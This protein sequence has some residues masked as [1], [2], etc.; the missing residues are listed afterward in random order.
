MVQKEQP[1]L[2]TR[3]D[4]AL[5]LRFLRARKFDYDR[6]MQLLLNYHTS[7]RAWPE[8]LM[9]GSSSVS[10]LVQ[11]TWKANDYPFEDNIRAIYLTLEKLIQH[12]GDSGEWDRHLADY[13]GGA[14]PGIQSGPVPGQEGC[15]HP[16][17]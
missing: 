3:L 2:R 11:E 9:D 1:N 5:L 17:G 7:R 16:S 12:R 15:Q 10:D 14:G 13:T 6:A 4:D 8:T